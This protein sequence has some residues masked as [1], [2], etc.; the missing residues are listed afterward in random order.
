LTEA[1]ARLGFGR[2]GTIGAR[3]VERGLRDLGE[4][5]GAVGKC[6]A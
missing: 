2:S 5:L 1:L 6:V 4:L 3:V